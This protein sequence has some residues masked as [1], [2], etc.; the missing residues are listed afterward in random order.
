MCQKLIVIDIACMYKCYYRTKVAN[1][2]FIY[3]MC[4]L[5]YQNV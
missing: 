3:E 2:V 4:Y 1:H 5:D